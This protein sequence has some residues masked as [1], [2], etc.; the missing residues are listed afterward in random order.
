MS[1]IQ[2]V[3]VVV[4]TDRDGAEAMFEQAIEKETRRNEVFL[5]KGMELPQKNGTLQPGAGQAIKYT[6][7]FLQCSRKLGN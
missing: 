6:S 4:K 3:A 1:Y 5:Y 2:I 7:V